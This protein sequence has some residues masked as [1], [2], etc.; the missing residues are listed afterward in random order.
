MRRSTLAL[1]LALITLP[2]QAQQD[3]S[4]LA[5]RGQQPAEA[6]VRQF[7]ANFESGV[8]KGCLQN[9]PRDLSNPA[10]YCRCYA[11][12]LVSQYQPA[13][14]AQINQYATSGS[15]NVSIIALMTSP[16][17]RGCRAGLNSAAGTAAD[18]PR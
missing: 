5:R 2:A 12:T 17:A 14:L 16:F 10:A 1:L 15:V 4:G 3:S 18:E 11:H 13:E 6:R 9:P 7:V 8:N